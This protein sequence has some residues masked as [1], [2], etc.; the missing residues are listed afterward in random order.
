MN[1]FGERDAWARVACYFIPESGPSGRRGFDPGTGALNHPEPE[2][3]H[4]TFFSEKTM[5][6]SYE[7]LWR[8]FLQRAHGRLRELGSSGSEPWN[9]PPLVLRAR[10]PRWALLG[11]GAAAS[12]TLVAALV[13]GF[14]RLGELL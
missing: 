12:V 1:H 2:F 3:G 11:A 10:L 7:S 6:K 8:P 9:P 4:S 14:A 5:R 13:L